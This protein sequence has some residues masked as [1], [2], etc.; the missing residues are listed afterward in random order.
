[1]G[2]G[3]SLASRIAIIDDEIDGSRIVIA[4]PCLW[5]LR[6]VLGAWLCCWALGELNA[7]RT[8][9]TGR[10]VMAGGPS[11]NLA[12]WLAFWTIFGGW[13]LVTWVWLWVG[14]E[15][16]IVGDEG[17]LIR[18]EVSGLGLTSRYGLAEV[19][20][21][22]YDPPPQVRSLSD[23]IKSLQSH[24]SG[25]MGTIVFDYDLGVKYFGVQVSEPDARR[26]IEAIS[27]KLKGPVAR[28]G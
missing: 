9:V 23:G 19:R 22:R 10:P 18:R 13:F 26:V 21:L 3:P 7:I 4:N 15:V 16:V 2:D 24:R 17:L 11:I 27:G 20:N 5:G 1:M 14:R 8:F 28:V 6:L 25:A 12:V